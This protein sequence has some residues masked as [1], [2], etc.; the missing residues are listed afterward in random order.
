MLAAANATLALAQGRFREAPALIARAYEIG[1]PTLAWNATAARTLQRFIYCRERGGLD[2]YL[3][4]VRDREDVFPSPLVHRSVLAHALV[5]LD[6]P[7]EAAA[8]D[9]DL[10]GHD[11]AD[12]HVDEQWFVSLSLLAETCALLGDADAGAVLYELL[13]PYADHNA[14]AVPE[15]ALD[16]TGRPL[17]LLAALLGRH[18]D[19][20]RHFADAVA[21][22]ERMGARVWLEH[23]R[24]AQAL[25]P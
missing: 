8:Y 22:N 1:A 19:A 15:L 4:E 18:D 13:E 2:H 21:M 9:D 17:G 7:D 25:R 16:S 12:W 20:E 24:R 3:A 23:T 11:L 6:R 10:M 14:V 5:Y